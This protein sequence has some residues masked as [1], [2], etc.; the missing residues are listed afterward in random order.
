MS[1][2]GESLAS[3]LT[4]S[5]ELRLLAA[6]RPNAIIAPYTNDDSDDDDDNDGDD[7][8][9]DAVI[10]GRN[11]DKNSSASTSASK[12][13]ENEG[14]VEVVESPHMGGERNAAKRRS[15]KGPLG[16]LV[17]EDY[18]AFP[19]SPQWGRPATY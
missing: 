5:T 8:G 14:E 1:E 7:D 11:D 9:D 4:R 16:S 6:A 2:D 13:K 19:P 12:S 3:S 18:G 10:I 15:T 17:L